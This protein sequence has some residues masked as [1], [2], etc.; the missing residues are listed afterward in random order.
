MELNII[1]IFVSK[2]SIEVLNAIPRKFSFYDFC[3]FTSISN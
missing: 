3:I 1:R 2:H